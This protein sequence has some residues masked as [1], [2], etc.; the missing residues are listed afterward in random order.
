MRV[1]A[2]GVESQSQVEFLRNSGCDF[3]QGYFIARP[4]TPE[5]FVKFVNG[6][7]PEGSRYIEKNSDSVKEDEMIMAG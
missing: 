1:V 6:A 7:E 3:A 4:L 5:Q 2:E